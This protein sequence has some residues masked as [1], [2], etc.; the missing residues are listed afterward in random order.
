MYSALDHALARLGIDPT[1][2]PEKIAA[3][4]SRSSKIT[5]L[6]DGSAFMTGTVS[7]PKEKTAALPAGLGAELLAM[8][9][10][11]RRPLPV[12]A[13]VPHTTSGIPMSSLIG[14][15]AP[16]M[17]VSA[18]RGASPAGVAQALT[19][20]MRVAPAELGAALRAKTQ[21][22]GAAE[23]GNALGM[24]PP[25]GANPFVPMTKRAS[26]GALLF[27]RR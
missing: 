26:L 24:T 12:S 19:P 7:G 11:G 13:I 21:A 9:S 1:Q 5:V 14:H 2:E 18:V 27:G 6:P 23:L 20:G 10:R 16:P 3:V 15:R 25:P 8:A 17:P 4:I 22:R